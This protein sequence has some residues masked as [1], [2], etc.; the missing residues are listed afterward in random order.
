VGGTWV[1]EGNPTHP[2]SPY[3]LLTLSI[4]GRL[5]NVIGLGEVTSIADIA[6]DDYQ[7]NS[8]PLR[9]AA[10]EAGWRFNNLNGQQQTAIGKPRREPPTQS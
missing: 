9:I 10:D 8:R 6:A 1:L 2:H 3:P 5:W 4:Y 7:R